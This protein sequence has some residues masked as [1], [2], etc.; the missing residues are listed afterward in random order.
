MHVAMGRRKGKRAIAC[1]DGNKGETKRLLT[2]LPTGIVTD[3]LSWLPL[4]SLFNCRY[5]CKTWLQI[6]SDPHFAKLH[7]SRSSMNILIQNER[8]RSESRNLLLYQIEKAPHSDR[9][10]IEEMMFTPRLNLPNSS[11]EFFNSCNGLLCLSGIK[12]KLVHVCNPV[13]G[14]FIT[15]KVPDED[16]RTSKSFCFGFS[17]KTNEAGPKAEVYTIGAG[18]WKSL[19]HVLFEI[20]TKRFNTYLR[21]A[22]HWVEYSVDQIACFDFEEVLFREVRAPP[23]FQPE[24]FYCL[25]L[26]VIEDCLCACCYRDDGSYRFEIWVMKDYGVKESLH[27][28]ALNIR[29][30]LTAIVISIIL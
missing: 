10:R 18:S 23:Q 21:G 3:I 5:V 14:E 2:D 26:G 25:I 1:Q 9:I 15:I 6:I 28:S 8:P 7:L 16:M 30:Y 20:G 27:R 24:P 13:L 17:V 22:F 4:K 29:F 11:F 19:G 12:E